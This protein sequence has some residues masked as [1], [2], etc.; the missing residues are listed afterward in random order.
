VLAAAFV[1]AA[2]FVGAVAIANAAP[3]TGVVH[4]AASPAAIPG[5]Y[6]VYLKS[7]AAVKTLGVD[8]V[9][10]TLARR[11]HGTVTATWAALHG[12][13]VSMSATD[14]THLAADPDVDHV[15]QD[16]RSAMV[17]PAVKPLS[18]PQTRAAG[19][20]LAVQGNPPGVQNDPP[21]PLDRI[22]Q[23]APP[24]DHEYDYADTT[25]TVTIYNID[26]GIAGNPDFENRSISGPNF[27]D[28]NPGAANCPARVIS[29][30]IAGV[31]AGLTYGVAKKAVVVSVRAFD[32]EGIASQQAIQNAFAWIQGNAANPA[33]DPAVVTFDDDD[34]CTNNQN[35][36]GPCDPSVALAHLL[37]ENALITAGIPV[38]A[39]AGDHGNNTDSCTRSSGSNTPFTIY[40]GATTQADTPA[41]FSD[42]GQCLTLW[43]PG[44]SVPTDSPAGAVTGSSTDYA[45]GYVAGA[46]ALIMG[47]PQFAGESPANL[48]NELLSRAS[49]AAAENQIPALGV[50]GSPEL[51]LFT[52]DSGLLAVG[53]PGGITLNAPGTSGSGNGLTMNLITYQSRIEQVT[54]TA[55]GAPTWTTPITSG[56]HNWQTVTTGLNPDGTIQMIAANTAGRLGARTPFALGST[57]WHKWAAMTA[58]PGN[59]QIVDSVLA[60]NNSNQMELFVTDRTGNVYRA[61]Q[62]APN[63]GTWGPWI[64]MDKAL[65]SI[66]AIANGHGKIDLFGVD[67]AG[68]IWVDEQTSNTADTWTPWS[69]LS[70]DL[71]MGTI[72][73]ALQANG[74]VAIFGI[75]IG[76]HLRWRI[77]SNIDTGIW[78]CCWT[79]PIPGTPA[80]RDV[81]TMTEATP[82]PHPPP[83]RRRPLRP[84]LPE[85]AE[86]PRRRLHRYLD[87]PHRHHPGTPITGRA[88]GRH[89]HS[90]AGNSARRATSV[91][92]AEHAIRPRRPRI[93]PHA[94]DDSATENRSHD[95]QT[96]TVH[97][98]AAP[99]GGRRP[100]RHEL[101]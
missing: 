72:A 88:D 49:E 81:I 83:H 95:P 14:A 89:R 39:P 84:A 48:K 32:C 55:P 67:G 64:P 82:D 44:D 8:D 99:R 43:A 76:R 15:D 77:E 70:S 65:H 85:R 17:K 96:P 58:P 79:A 53:D 47:Q 12:F 78:A 93:V 42:T 9:A 38:V 100:R 91:S 30:G 56:S 2:S 1:L 27:A 63:T 7:D 21:W 4:A 28:D 16:Q 57:L 80:L 51:L 40:V 34:L 94:Q 10:H 29:T 31:E 11:Y 101:L 66:S 92:A 18:T 22:D 97:T 73:T 24:L 98:G 74:T 41:A 19:A 52:G 62:T 46:L 37:E 75:D 69:Q 45:A 59:G 61:V 87:P 3:A 26:G 5:S 20:P 6:L 13:G 23:I 86:H 90:A 60:H 50:N 35:Q 68:Q 71:G 36:V 33:A 54:Q 25:G